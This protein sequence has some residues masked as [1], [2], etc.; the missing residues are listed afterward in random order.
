MVYMELEAEALLDVFLILGAEG[1]D[2]AGRSGMVVIAA[3]IVSL[4]SL[5]RFLSQSVIV[6]PV[7]PEPAAEYFVGS[8]VVA[9]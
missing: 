1:F 5:A 7:E 8:A 3:V 9:M 6:V 4:E 2:T